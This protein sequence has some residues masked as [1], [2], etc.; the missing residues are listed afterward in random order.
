MDVPDDG[1]V[2]FPSS[3]EYR[4]RIFIV[5]QIGANCNGIFNNPE[6]LESIVIPSTIKRITKFADLVLSAVFLI[7]LT[8]VSI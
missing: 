5:N 3:V 2:V 7:F 6:T 8:N 4:D 1:H